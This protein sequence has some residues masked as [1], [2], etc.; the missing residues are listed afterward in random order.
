M[1]TTTRKDEVV[2]WLPPDP[3]AGRTVRSRLRAFLDLPDELQT[4]VAVVVTE[5]VGRAVA[6]LDATGSVRRFEVRL[7]RLPG[8]ARIEVEHGAARQ[9]FDREPEI[10]DLSERLVD[11]LSLAR[12]AEGTTAWVVV[13]RI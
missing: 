3:Q 6:H 1:A 5:L 10:E 7:E 11:G 9:R 12:G 8:R 13:A 4:A 2:L